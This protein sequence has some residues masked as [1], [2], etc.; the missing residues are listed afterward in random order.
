[1]T[2]DKWEWV[3]FLKCYVRRL[4]FG[5]LHVYPPGESGEWG[6]QVMTSKASLSS[7]MEWA[8][9]EAAAKR[10]AIWYYATILAAEL[11]EHKWALGTP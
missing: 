1:M 4:A 11:E 3:Q 8:S 10:L 2:D 7:D 6:W 9:S 5:A